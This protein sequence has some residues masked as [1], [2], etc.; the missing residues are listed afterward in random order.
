MDVCQR[1]LERHL[2]IVESD[3]DGV[4]DLAEQADPCRAGGDALLGQ[5]LLLGLGEE[6]G[7]EAPGRLEEVA[8]AGQL[9]GGEQLGDPLVWD[10][11]PLEL[12]EQQLGRDGDRTLL[13]ALQQRAAGGIRR[14]GGEVEVRE[15]AGDSPPHILGKRVQVALEGGVIGAGVQTGEVPADVLGSG[16]RHGRKVN[17]LESVRRRGVSSGDK[18]REPRDHPRA[19][20]ID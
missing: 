5:H 13:D 20:A 11:G 17:D 18:R 6:V 7:A 19:G 14:V 2:P 9:G 4:G 12:E 1:L 16:R 8:P 10:R 15:R 3:A